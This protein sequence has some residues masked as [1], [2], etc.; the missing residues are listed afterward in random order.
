MWGD[1]N[2]H[3]SGRNA[4]ASV[5][6]EGKGPVSPGSCG[7]GHTTCTD[8]AAVTGIHIPI[9]ASLGGL[10]ECVSVKAWGVSH[11]VL[12]TGADEVDLGAKP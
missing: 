5:D 11:G 8:P 3:I 10:A 9:F 6:G 12:E 1:D 7:T 2:R 4:P